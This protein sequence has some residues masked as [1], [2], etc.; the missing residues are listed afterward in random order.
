MV[1]ERGRVKGEEGADGFRNR[2][3]S[4]DLDRV[5]GPGVGDAVE[6]GLSQL[7]RWTQ[8]LTA[9]AGAAGE[10]VGGAFEAGKHLDH[11]VP[12]RAG[13]NPRLRWEPAAYPSLSWAGLSV[14]CSRAIRA[15]W[16]ACHQPHVI[17]DSWKNE[18]RFNRPGHAMPDLRV[19]L[20]KGGDLRSG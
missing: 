7:L 9:L 2:A 14:S 3:E 5:L 18:R 19:N 11:G 8:E 4:M 12:G 20:R 16:R 15:N 1:P 17:L 6:D 13:A 10:Q